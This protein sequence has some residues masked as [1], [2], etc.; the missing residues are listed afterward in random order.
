MNTEEFIRRSKEKHGD[1][2]DYSKSV[3]VNPKTNIIVTCKKHGDFLTKPYN[4]MNGTGCR[5]CADE[6]NA[7][8]YRKDGDIFINDAV[9]VHGDKYDYSKVE[10]VNWKTKVCIICPEHGEFFQTPNAHL[11]GQGCPKCGIKSRTEQRTMTTEEFIEKAKRIHGDKYDYSK[12]EYLNTGENVLIKCN[13]CGREFHQTPE[14]HLQNKGCPY[15]ANQSSQP[16]NEIAD[17]LRD[18]LGEDAVLQRDRKILGGKELDIYVPSL[19]LAIEYNGLRWH[20]TE[21]TENKNSHLDKLNECNKKGIKLITIFED[22]WI[23]GKN[24]VL[25]KLKHI[26]KHNNGEKVFGRKTNIVVIDKIT[27]KKFLE[28]N[29]IQ[30]FAPSTVYL[31]CIYNDK[32]VAVMTF[33]NVKDEWELNRYATDINLQCIGVGGKMFKYFIKKYN[34]TYVKSFADRRWTIDIENNLYIKLG[35][36]I[37]SILEPDYRYV[38]RLER[39]HKFNFR[40]QILHKKY[41]FPLSMTELEMTKKLGIFRIYDCGIV[42]YVWKST[43]IL[44]ST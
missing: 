13:K 29:H 3:Y 17:F 33:K 28:I 18:N 21:F 31:G 7:L 1:L 38:N 15:C 6:K 26:I 2:F 44:K 36:N 4:H 14:N 40:K 25:S 24:I 9:K 35:F 34:P 27:A 32:L 42:K 43:E 8:K 19:K 23:N 39:I 20:S 12:V 10:Y 30:G 22:E 11:N 41:G 5:K 37:D 16:E